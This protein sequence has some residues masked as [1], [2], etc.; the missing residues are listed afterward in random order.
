[1]DMQ[2]SPTA[3]VVALAQVTG[4]VRVYSYSE[5][6]TKEQMT[7]DYHEDSCR[8]IEFS[9]DGNMI[10]TGSKDMSLAVITNGN[11][12]GRILEAHPCP[13]HCIRHIENG[14]ILATGDDDGLIRIWDLRAAPK[15]KKHAI[16]MEFNDHEGTVS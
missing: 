6:E 14:N 11:M 15:G 2:L 7:F 3:N 9:P 5:T 4:H 13:I 10:Y 1:M 12:A 8:A 16:A